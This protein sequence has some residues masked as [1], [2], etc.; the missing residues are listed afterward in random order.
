[1]T[2][3]TDAH[4]FPDEL[5]TAADASLP[6]RF[7]DRMM[8]NLH[9]P[10]ASS[11]AELL[12]T[13]IVGAGIYPARDTTDGYAMAVLPG[14]QRNVRFSTEL[15]ATRPGAVG[16]L[17]WTVLEPLR[18][19]RLVLEDNPTGCSFDVVWTARTPPLVRDVD[20]ANAATE[21]SSFVHLVQS[22]RY[23]GQL[24]VDGES[25]DVGGWFGQ[26]DRSRGV[27]TMSGGQGLH[28]WFQAQFPE[29]C[30][31]FLL[32]EGRDGSRLLL[33]G[34]VLGEDG[35]LDPVVDVAHDLVLDAGLDLRSGTVR[36]RTGS[37]RERVL[38]IDASGRGVHMAGGGYGGAHGRP[39]GVDHLEH[40][41]YRLDGSVTPRG[42]DTALTDRPAVLSSAGE[43][44]VGIV[45][46]AATRSP[47]YRYRPT[48]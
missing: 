15:G 6:E 5:L 4:D 43:R 12:P 40:D 36:V 22:G 32:V 46:F 3:A 17:R 20:V 18:S 1:M 37:G 29:H 2:L 16:P 47:S 7:F 34:A 19:W 25:Q 45:E 42:L 21:A 23:T 10:A 44:G 27:R 38:D 9:P 8:F 26:R 41:V 13:L 48:L 30:V 33:E 28:V 39:R 11:S 24:T 14:E 31:S 35:T